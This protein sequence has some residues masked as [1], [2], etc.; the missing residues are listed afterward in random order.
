LVLLGA[1]CSS[2]SESEDTSADETSDSDGS[3]V[4]EG[5]DEDSESDEDEGESAEA[6]EPSGTLRVATRIAVNSLNPHDDQ[7]PA[8]FSYYG[9]L[10]EGLV[11]Q[12][13]E[14]GSFEPWLADS[15]EV[16]DDGLTV[17]FAL[18]EG[19]EF[20]DGTPFDAE[21]VKANIEFVKTAEPDQVIPPVKGQMSNVTE[22][23]AAGDY[24][25]VFHLQQPGEIALISWLGRNSGLM[26][27]P[28]VLGDA[29]ANP[30]GTGPFV[31]NADDSAA[32]LTHIVFD[33]NSSYWDPAAVGV[34]GV[35]I[36]VIADS[37]ARLQGYE[38]GQYDV[39]VAALEMGEPSTGSLVIGPSVINSF[40]VID[41][42]GET[43]P[44]LADKEVRCAMA[45]A[46]NREGLVDQIYAPE[47]AI[48]NQWA[49]S[50]DQYAYIDD[51]EIAEFDL[52]AA[53][54]A[55]EETGAE[56]FSFSNGYLPDGPFELASTAWAGGLNELGI[57]MDN[58][59]LNPPTGAEMF[60]R[61]GE[62]VYPIQNIP[63]NEPHPLL[64]LQQRA[65]PDGSLNPSGAVP[66]G[67]AELVESASTKSVDDAEADIEAAWRIMVEECIWIP[68]QNLYDG[69][70]VNDNVS[71]VEKISGVPIAFWP[72]GVRVDG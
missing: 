56:P 51:L 57:T 61:F 68:Y 20:S 22:V 10:Y 53:K 3:D 44:A 27:S 71:G 14:D 54:A 66:E 19:V 69:Y 4:T 23:E 28:E 9:F 1:A 17:T 18:K 29:A 30:T 39:A 2:D 16:S 62:G 15:W 65:L 49:G 5:D 63:I 11:R 55:F 70:W 31:Y 32:D 33:A 38:A 36:D 13:A 60:A 46:L 21:A 67:V 52:D 7:T 26:V 35:E 25:V 58:E 59:V 72:Q 34:E 43:I 42:Q 45:Q 64:T 6:A 40:T 41:W 12:N 8:T 37:A 50:E 24:E 47:E 48:R